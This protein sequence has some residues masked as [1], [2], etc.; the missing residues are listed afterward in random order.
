M[1][2][3][4]RTQVR[5]H[6]VEVVGRDRLGRQ[7]T[8]ALQAFDQERVGQLV[9]ALACW[10]GVLR[11]AVPGC[12]QP[13]GGRASPSKHLAR[14]LVGHHGTHAVTE[15][16]ERPLRQRLHLR[17]QARGQFAQVVECRQV[18]Q[19]A[20]AWV[21]DQA[22]APA[23]GQARCH[24]S[25]AVTMPAGV[26]KPDQVHGSGPGCVHAGSTWRCAA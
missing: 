23:R 12:A 1:V 3:L 17:Q 20:P 2:C 26:V 9:Q 14:N 11:R 18:G 22:D 19:R 8:H 25:V 10:P 21:L 7:G 5:A 6:E 24:R 13:Q 4:A 16:G 15:E